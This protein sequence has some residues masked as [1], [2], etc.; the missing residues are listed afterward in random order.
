MADP[1]V[2]LARLV[3]SALSD[4]LGAQ[5]RGR[6]PADPAVSVRRLPGQ[7]G[8]VRWPGSSAGRRGRWPRTWRPSWRT[9]TWSSRP[10]SAA[11]GSS[12]SRCAA[13]GLPRRRPACWATRGWTWPRTIRCRRSLSTTRRP[14]W[15]RKC[16]SGTCGRR[17]SGTRW[18]GCSST[19]A[20]RSSGPTTSGTGAPSSARWSSTCWTSA[21]PRPGRCWPT[22][23]STRSTRRPRRASTPTRRSPSG[24]G[25]GWSRS[26]PATP[27]RCGCGSCWCT[28]PSSTTTRS[29]RGWASR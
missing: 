9:V 8:N 2:V 16:T 3:S 13:S 24:P 19:S 5:V 6:R 4:A 1:E 12:T 23:T 14:T 22:A 11:P 18:S 7:R 29:T 27:R 21:S 20:T 15:P 26:R 10:R 28:A 25:G 17:W